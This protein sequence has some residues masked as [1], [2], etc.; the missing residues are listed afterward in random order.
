VV[1]RANA[2]S[3][4]SYDVGLNRIPLTSMCSGWLMAKSTPRAK[5]PAGIAYF[6]SLASVFGGPVGALRPAPGATTVG[7]KIESSAVLIFDA[8]AGKRRLFRSVLPRKV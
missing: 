8:S 1:G 6:L 4:N 5:L 3:R 2:A 7:G